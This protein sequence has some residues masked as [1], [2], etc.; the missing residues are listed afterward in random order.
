MMGAHLIKN[1][2]GPLLIDLM[3]RGVVSL[4][5]G[6]GACTIHDTELAYCGGTSESVPDVLPKGEFGFARETGQIVNGAFL[7][8]YKRKMGA[9]EALGAILAGKIPFEL[10]N[11]ASLA[12]PYRVHSLFYNAYRLGIPFTIHATIGTDI[13]DQHPGA[14]AEAKGYASGIDFSIFT[15]MATRLQEGGVILNVGGAVTQPEVLLKAV[16]MAANVGKAPKGIL[17]AVFDLFDTNLEDIRN[18]E[19]AGYYRRDIKST[20]VRIPAA[21]EGRG[22]YIQGNQKETFTAFYRHLR[23]LLEK[24]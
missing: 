11:G 20:V 15:E 6:N 5:A 3:E 9:G 13:V 22:L 18:E 23:Y 12:F 24:D 8:A 16:S 10:D 14:S 4:L 19:K 2:L 17:T 7:E 1:G 21:F